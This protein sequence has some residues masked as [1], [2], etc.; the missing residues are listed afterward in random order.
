MENA[1]SPII[2]TRQGAL[3]GITEGDVQV[4]RAIPYAAPPVGALRWR[5][6]QPVQNW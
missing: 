1:S 6:P 4:W 3:C 2:T 5:S